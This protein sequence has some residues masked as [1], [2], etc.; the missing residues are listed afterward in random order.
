[1]ATHPLEVVHIDYLCLE[2]GKGKEENI[3]VVTDHFT[4]YT[5]AYVTQS[6]MT[7]TRAKA[8]WDN[9]IIHYGLPEKIL[10]DQGRNFQSK[11]IANLCKLMGTRKLRTSLYRPQMN[12]QCERFN[13]TLISMLGALP[14]KHKSN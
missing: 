9:F 1:M 5:Q 4:Y 3:L 7:L 14:L 13:S 6:Q 10:S 11:L 8:L 12:F 2:P